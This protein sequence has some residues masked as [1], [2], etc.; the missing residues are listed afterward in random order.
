MEEL[1]RLSERPIDWQPSE[2]DPVQRIHPAIHVYVPSKFAYKL[3]RRALVLSQEAFY[4]AAREYWP[5]IARNYPGGPHEVRFGRTELDLDTGFSPPWPGKA[6]SKGISTYRVHHQLRSLVALRNIVC[7]FRGDAHHEANGIDWVLEAAQ[8]FAVVLMDERRARKIRGLRD[9]LRDRAMLEY[10]EIEDMQFF[11]DMPFCE[12]GYK[13]HQESL[14]C[15][16]WY[17]SQNP[18]SIDVGLPI[19]IRRVAEAWGKSNH[20]GRIEN[21]GCDNDAILS[22]S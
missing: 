1:T 10:K 5:S 13:E 22:W 11:A 7:H 8:S 21:G 17:D 4:V 12:L 20:L 9:A 14:F 16:V 19:A 6:E 3:L 18:L 2:K 15:N